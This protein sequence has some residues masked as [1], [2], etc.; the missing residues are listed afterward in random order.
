MGAF[1]VLLVIM[2]VALCIPRKPIVGEFVP[3]EFDPA[4]VAGVPEAEE[5]L[6][7]TTLYKEGMAYSVSICGV[8]AA[9]GK[10]LTVYFTNDEGNEKYLKLRVMD[11]GGNT[12]GETGLLK[13]GE[14]VK[15]VSLS[16]ELAAGTSLKLKIMGYE[17]E[18]YTSAGAVSLNVT[19]GG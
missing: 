12:L 5:S 4:A 6:G 7:Y 19:V 9:D 18:D 15:S 11:T 10:A 1:A 3:P 8:P 14:Y 2:T 17:P 16:K 13:P